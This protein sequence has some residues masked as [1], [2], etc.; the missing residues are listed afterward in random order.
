MSAYLR[1]RVGRLT[2][3]ADRAAIVTVDTVGGDLAPVARLRTVPGEAIVLDAA[4]LI[5]EPV[6]A[7]RT[8]ADLVRF[9]LPPVG[10]DGLRE[11]EVNVMVDHVVRFETLDDH[12]FR[13]LPRGVG[14]IGRIVDAVLVEEG[15]ASLAFRLRPL[16]EI[17]RSPSASPRAWRRAAKTLR[18][19]A[20]SEV[21]R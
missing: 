7:E 17:A 19:S 5:G 21:A 20:G 6:P 14:A 12:A 2:L 3:L 18:P 13:P 10:A 16:D 9:R 11:T 4:R 15:G 1:V 8:A